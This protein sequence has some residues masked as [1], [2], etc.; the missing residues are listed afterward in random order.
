V[1]DEK[2]KV[3]AEQGLAGKEV[4]FGIRPDDI[5]DPD[6]ESPNIYGQPVKCSV[7]VTEMMGNEIFLYL[8]AGGKEFRARVDPRSQMRVG[9]D[10]QVTFNMNYM[11]IFD[12]QTEMAVR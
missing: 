10:V 9:Q 4:V 5:Y 3:Y 1:P 7:D 11:Q 12:R 6:F 8:I 2:A